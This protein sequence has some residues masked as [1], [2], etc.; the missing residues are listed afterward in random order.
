MREAECKFSAKDVEAGIPYEPE[1]PSFIAKIEVGKR[2]VDIVAFIAL[3]RAIG[4]VGGTTAN[5]HRD[6]AYRPHDLESALPL[7]A[8]ALRIETGPVEP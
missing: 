7:V 5:P 1:A 4:G 2:W 8:L 3:A 6:V